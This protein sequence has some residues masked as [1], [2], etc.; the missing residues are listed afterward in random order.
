MIAYPEKMMQLPTREVLAEIAVNVFR[1]LGLQRWRVFFVD[2]LPESLKSKK[3]LPT[4]A[5]NVRFH[6]NTDDQQ[7][8]NLIFRV[9]RGETR[10]PGWEQTIRKNLQVALRQAHFGESGTH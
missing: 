9:S 3:P 7:S 5:Y 1:E 4:S 10:D 8:Y 6:I 2:V